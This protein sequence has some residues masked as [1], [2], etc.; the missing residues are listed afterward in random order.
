MKK[1]VTFLETATL[2]IMNNH[3]FRTKTI[4]PLILKVLSIKI[5]CDRNKIFIVFIINFCVVKNLKIGDTV[6]YLSSKQHDQLQIIVTGF[7][8]PFRSF[9]ATTLLDAFP[10]N[11]SFTYAIQQKTNF[12]ITNPYFNTINSELGKIKSN[13]Q[14][15]Y[16]QLINIKNVKEQRIAATEIEV[17]NVTHLIALTIIFKEFFSDLFLS[18]NN[19]NLYL[20]Q[21]I[22]YKN[23]RNKLDHR[24]CKTLE[25]V[26]M[27]TTLEFI[28]NALL[29]LKEDDT[30]FWEK[31]WSDI[32]KEIVSLQTSNTDIPIEINNINSMPFPDMKI[33]CRDKEIEMLKE[34]VYGRPGSLKKQSSLVLYGY[35]GVGKTALVLECI[36]QIIQ[37]IQDNT[38]INN[39]SPDFLLFFTAKEEVLSF[40]DTTGR[41]QNRPNR[42][43]FKDVDTLINA[44]YAELGI[45]SFINYDKSGLIVIDNLETLPIADRKKLDEFIRFDCPP[46]IQF[47]IT[48]RNEEDYD[49]R[50]KVAGFEDD[51]A[52]FEFIDTYITENNLDVVLSDDEKKTLLQISMGNTLVLVLCI[53]RLS[54]KLI[55][56][57]G[58]IADTTTPASVSKLKNEIETIPANGFS[59]ISEYMFKNSFQ[60]LEQNYKN[61]KNDIAIILKIFAVYPSATIDLYTISML[62]KKPFNVVNPILDLLCKYLIIEKNDEAYMLNQFAAKYIIELFMPDSQSYEKIS[63]DIISST[64][65]I[66][67]ELVELQRNID[68]NYNLKRI[69]QDWNVITDGDKIAVAKAFKI[70]GEVDQDCK[71]S[72]RFHVSAALESA[73]KEI[74]ILEQN[75]MHPYIKYQ[76]ARIYHRISDSNL[77]DSN[78]FEEIIRSYNDT[79]W[80]IKTNPVYCSIKHTRSFAAILWKYGIDLSSSKSIE[81]RQNATRYLEESVLLFEQLH[82]KST[83]YFKCLILLGNVY[84]DLYLDNK[85][86]NIQYLRKARNISNKLRDKRNDYYGRVKGD[87]ITLRDRLQQYG[88]F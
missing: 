50:R 49:I 58:I 2:Y 33:V 85:E 68:N 67:N 75:T 74:E 20:H 47:I 32:S 78:Y 77:L 24:G 53:R 38:T 35:G 56:I 42:Y 26:D 8:I 55:S 59:I 27:A 14:K 45:D 48:S 39:Y 4:L 88:S 13:P 3:I 63:S 28:T 71:R 6:M 44:V 15:T 31:S 84:L 54:L 69:I 76:K 82:D 52:G 17:P 43:S 22:S 60:E 40:S 51:V 87:A 70:Y 18:Y 25:N 73:I 65:R 7:E 57:E 86:K 80:T 81:H 5:N 9:I 36:K 61:H 83:E 11:S 34:F 72:S 21:S 62:S 1:D 46:Q 23:V 79:I 19:E 64:R 37:D 30:L 66:Q 12:T 29:C 10:S 41:I 16:T